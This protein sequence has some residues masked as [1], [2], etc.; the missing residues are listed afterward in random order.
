MNKHTKAPWIFKN[1]KVW[2][3]VIWIAD[4]LQIRKSALETAANG[5]LIAAAP[6]M[7]ELIKGHVGPTALNPDCTEYHFR[8]LNR[9][10]AM[11]ALIAKIEGV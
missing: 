8:R 1:G 10:A 11:V 2:A 4:I 3:G 9:E 6:E 7:L 5:R